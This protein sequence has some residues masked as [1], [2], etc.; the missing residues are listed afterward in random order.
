[1]KKSDALALKLKQKGD[2]LADDVSRGLQEAGNEIEKFG[3]KI[4]PR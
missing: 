2:L 3:K 1:V 4:S